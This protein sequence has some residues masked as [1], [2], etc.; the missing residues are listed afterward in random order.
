VNP[1]VTKTH[2]GALGLV[3]VVMAMVSC[4]CLVSRAQY[5]E[6]LTESAKVRA[7]ALSKQ[8]DDASK[9]QDLEQ[10]L[11]AAEAA[12]QERDA[13]LSDLST[14]S[15]NLQAQLDE[16][17]AM[18]QQLRSELSR[19]GQDVDKILADRG[20]LAKAL[21]DAK[22][23]LDE[24]RKAQ[25]VAEDRARLFRDFAQ[26]F[27]GLIDAGQLRVEPRRG[28]LVINVNGD[29]LFDEGKAEIRTAGKGALMEISRVL[30]ATA[31][32]KSGKGFLVTAH[33]DGEP[34]AK[35]RHFK[36]SW[37]LTTAR[38]V[39]LVEY[40][41]SLH[42]PAESLTAAGAGAFDPLVPGDSADGRAKNRRVEIALLGAAD[43]TV[44]VASHP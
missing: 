14:A 31:P 18:N 36:S 30:A 10:K 7:D 26:R 5:Q 44:V 23:R 3:A 6:C 16:A 32:A 27:K 37:E 9:I 25:A 21:D 35:T 11:A 29:L 41:V 40:L 15:H 4:G 13:K 24:L 17:T 19:V 39:A 8:K 38:A 34:S 43:E 42:V 33:V 22:A 28:R 1:L 20:T 12:T 2:G